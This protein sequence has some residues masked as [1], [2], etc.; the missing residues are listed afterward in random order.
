MTY[1][2]EKQGEGYTLHLD[3]ATVRQLGID[4]ET[5]LELE[6]R[7]SELVV[8][9]EES[10]PQMEFGLGREAVAASIERLRPRYQQ[11]LRNLAE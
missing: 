7:G 8:R 2:L 11:M 6:V 10:M 9:A 4:P 1:K 3:E 5:P